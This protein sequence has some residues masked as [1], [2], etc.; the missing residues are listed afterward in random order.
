M[1]GQNILRELQRKG[2][3]AA[4]SASGGRVLESGKLST[5]LVLRR[6]EDVPGFHLE[7][8]RQG[9][10]EKIESPG[11]C[12]TRRGCKCGQDYQRIR[13]DQIAK[14]RHRKWSEQRSPANSASF[15]RQTVE[16]SAKRHHARRDYAHFMKHEGAVWFCCHR[17]VDG[18]VSG[19]TMGT[20]KTMKVKERGEI[21]ASPFCRIEQ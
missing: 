18:R 13:Y 14:F 6:Q 2:T 5:G 3:R 20:V 10:G 12:E 4:F 1:R 17:T 8:E 11:T 9:Q 16:N 7:L 21:C 15:L 19:M